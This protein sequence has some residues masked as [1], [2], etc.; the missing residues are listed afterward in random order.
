M[1]MQVAVGLRMKV[2]RL[3]EATKHL[4]SDQHLCKVGEWQKAWDGVEEL[5]SLNSDLSAKPLA[6]ASL[7][8]LSSKFEDIPFQT[9]SIL[10]LS[11]TLDPKARRSTIVPV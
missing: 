2:H 8:V 5:Y 4:V 1:G 7:S 11:K 6:E 10:P 3:L 9:K